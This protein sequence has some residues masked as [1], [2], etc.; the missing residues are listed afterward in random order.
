VANL[1]L[2]KLAL[3]GTDI[4]TFAL[5]ASRTDGDGSLSAMLVPHHDP[6]LQI[7]LTHEPAFPVS[8]VCYSTVPTEVLADRRLDQI[9]LFLEETRPANLS[10]RRQG[11][12]ELEISL[13]IYEESFDRQSLNL[14]VSEM[15]LVR[16]ILS[17]RLQAL[18]CESQPQNTEE[19]GE[20]LHDDGDEFDPR[21]DEFEPIA[22]PPQS[23]VELV[24]PETDL[25]P[26]QFAADPSE[27]GASRSGSRARRGSTLPVPA[28]VLEDAP[29]T[30]SPRMPVGVQMD[31]VPAFDPFSA[32]DSHK[33]GPS[34]AV[35]L[36]KQP[37]NVQP[38]SL[39]GQ[40]N[41]AP[42]PEADGKPVFDP[43]ASRSP[44]SKQ[45]PATIF[46]G[47]KQ[48]IKVLPSLLPGLGVKSEAPAP[49]Q[50][51]TK[52]CPKCNGELRAKA[53]FCTWCGH[54]Y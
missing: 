47:I 21:E 10:V 4:D 54:R 12:Q 49:D 35:P 2:A 34:S 42:T 50:A 37:L 9:L 45:G 53:R 18:D 43:F 36:D 26:A 6:S 40:G 11:D 32:Q 30:A 17:R 41:Q 5:A 8:L 19:S 3:W 16:R 27:G 22:T 14:A 33:K 31:S 29:S 44:S 13:W 38:T 39:P 51:P 20:D 1:I 52:H 23:T 7:L 24:E 48:P 25:D 46:P 15:S 28:S